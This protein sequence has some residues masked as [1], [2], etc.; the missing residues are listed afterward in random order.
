MSMTQ[1]MINIISEH[2][3]L[4]TLTMGLTVAV[5]VGTAIGMLEQSHMAYAIQANG[6]L[7]GQVN[8]GSSQHC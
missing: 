2:L 1:K 4:L 6:G 3:K 5:S 7:Q 8:S